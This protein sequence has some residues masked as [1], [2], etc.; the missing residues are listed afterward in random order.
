VL[1]ARWVRDH[2]SPDDVLATNVHCQPVTYL[3]DTCDARVFWL[4]AYAERRVLVEGWLF[5]PR[6]AGVQ[7]PFWDQAL[8][9]LNEAA[10]ADPTPERL[11]ELRD[12]YGV[13][14]LVVENGRAGQAEPSPRLAELADRRH[15][16]GSITV[17]EIPPSDH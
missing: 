5:A 3:R 8:F 9:D 7:G 2:S 4:S 17:Y 14:W 16:E 10:I 6:V 12:R 15:T 11:A 13:R 1:A